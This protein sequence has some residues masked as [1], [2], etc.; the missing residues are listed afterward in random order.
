MSVEK[1]FFFLT[2]GC[3]S[4]LKKRGKPLRGNSH[5]QNFQKFF[6]NFS[7]L[8]KISK[9]LKFSNHQKFFFKIFFQQLQIFFF[10]NQKEKEK[11]YQKMK[12]KMIFSGIFLFLFYCLSPSLRLHSPED[13]VLRGKVTTFF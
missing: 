10:L 12:K 6:K 2:G 8:S 3:F 11:K 4:F 5:S 7:K 1:V 9:S 13:L